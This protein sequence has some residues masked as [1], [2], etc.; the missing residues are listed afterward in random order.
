[1]EQMVAHAPLA[2]GGPLLDR[3][4]LEPLDR[5]LHGDARAHEI[6]DQA[7]FRAGVLRGWERRRRLRAHGLRDRELRACDRPRASPARAAS[8]RAWAAWES[9]SSRRRAFAA[10]PP[11]SSPLASSQW[12]ALRSRSLLRDRSLPS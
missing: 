10:T 4:R 9:A 8:W 5:G 12:R 11:F 6:E 3:R 2:G 1:M 7:L